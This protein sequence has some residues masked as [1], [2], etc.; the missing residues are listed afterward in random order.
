MATIEVVVGP[1][2]GKSLT[3]DVLGGGNISRHLPCRFPPVGRRWRERLVVAPTEELR[4][5]LEVILGS[6]V[7]GSLGCF[8][9]PVTVPT[10]SPTRDYWNSCQ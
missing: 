3:G 6:Q 9:R 5:R 10:K 8:G 7:L 1:A 2:E 4:R